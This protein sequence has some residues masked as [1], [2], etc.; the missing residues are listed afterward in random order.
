MTSYENLKFGVVQLIVDYMEKMEIEKQRIKELES[1]MGNFGL[2]DP[3]DIFELIYLRGKRDIFT[4]IAKDFD[5][6]FFR[7]N[8]E[9]TNI[10]KEGKVIKAK[11]R[12]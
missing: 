5:K 1:N 12:K 2:G 6:L 10:K 3:D 7:D 8:I 4:D 11:F 9:P